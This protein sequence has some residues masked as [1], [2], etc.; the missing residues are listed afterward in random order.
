MSARTRDSPPL[1]VRTP[2]P[3]SQNDA[4]ERI[5]ERG[6]SRNADSTGIG[7]HLARTLAR[8][9]R[10]SL[11]LDPRL[12]ARFEL[13]L[14]RADGRPGS[15]EAHDAHSHSPRRCISAT[16]PTGC[17][18][19]CSAPT[20]AS[21]P[22]PAS[23]SA[24]PPPAR[25]RARS[26][27]PGSPG[28]SPGRCRWP[29]ASTCRSAPSATPSRPTSASRSASCTR[30]G[31]ELRELAAIYERRGLPPALAG[32]VARRCSRR[33]T[34][35]QAHARDE[36]GLDEE[37][38]ARPL[39]AAWASALSFSAGAALP[40]LAVAAD[41][42]PARASP[43]RRRDADR[44]GAARRRRR[45]ARRRA[46]APRRRSASSSGARR[47]W[48]SPRASA[49][50]SAPSPERQSNRFACFQGQVRANVASAS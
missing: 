12:T 17:A 7:L 14:R 45:A 15:R 34:R 21:S 37:R 32:E 50:S 38:L 22:P 43:R 48:R 19:P 42:A 23:S 2:A 41:A 3:A 9:D 1:T 31:R 29:P 40:L 20:T 11:R 6:A 24:L 39:Q 35:S 28:W 25:R 36:L 8:A 16:A 4:A 26:S 49:R 30:P 46:P 33:A 44:A 5:F 13:R 10:G 27:R 18:P 47:R